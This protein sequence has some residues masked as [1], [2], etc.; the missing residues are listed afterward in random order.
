LQGLP[1]LPISSGVT[2]AACK[3][4]IKQR[5]CGLG[6]R[7]KNKGNSSGIEFTYISSNDK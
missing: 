4:L 3:T 6:M 2:D 7:W 1:N 5:L